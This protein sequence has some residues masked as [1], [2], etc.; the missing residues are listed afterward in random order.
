MVKGYDTEIQLPPTPYKINTLVKNLVDSA[1]ILELDI[2]S[3]ILMIDY[4]VC[5]YVISNKADLLT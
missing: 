2:I 3:S 5:D 1:V 4:V